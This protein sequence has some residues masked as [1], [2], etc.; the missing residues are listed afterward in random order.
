MYTPVNPSFTIKKWGLKGSKLIRHGFV[1]KKFYS[2]IEV[3]NLTGNIALNSDDTPNYKTNFR[4]T[5][6]SSTS[7]VK[8]HSE[9]HILTN[10]HDETKQRD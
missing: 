3:I 6:K 7:P 2:I 4:S 10:S 9:S 8:H 1:M 5:Y